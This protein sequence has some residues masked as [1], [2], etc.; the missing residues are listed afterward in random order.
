MGLAVGEPVEAYY[1]HVFR[2][3]ICKTDS[4]LAVKLISIGSELA[5]FITGL[6]SAYSVPSTIYRFLPPDARAYSK[7]YFACTPAR[8]IF[9]LVA[10]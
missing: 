10:V 2:K 8:Q 7:P 3:N 5:S 4:I 1:R 6:F 9:N